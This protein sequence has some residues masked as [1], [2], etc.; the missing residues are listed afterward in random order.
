VSRLVE[1]S[2]KDL[3]GEVNKLHQDYIMPCVHSW[4]DVVFVEGRGTTLKD[5]EGKEYLDCFAGVAVVNAGHCHPKIVEAVREQ[6]GKLTH[7]SSLFQTV[8]EAYLA[9]KISDSLPIQRGKPKKVYFCNSGSE[10]NDHAIILAKKFS[11]KFEI[12]GLQNGYHGR[13]GSTISASGI[14]SWLA[15]M[16]PFVPGFLHAPSYYCYRCPLGH[17][18]GPP[19]C[20]YACAQYIKHMLNTETSSSVAAFI[21]EPAYGVGGVIPAPPDYF[22]EVKRILDANNILFIADEVQTGF[23]RMG[24]MFGIENY[25]VDP[26]IMTMAKGLASGFPIGAVASTSEIADSYHGP[27]FS[28]YGGN[29][30]SCVAALA[31]LDVL[32]EEKLVENSARVGAHTL[33]VMIALEERHPSLDCVDGKGLMIGA[34]V[35]K[36]K[37]TREPA[38]DPVLE[39]ILRGMLEKGVIIGRGGLFYNRIRF[40]PPLCITEAEVDRAMDAID[41]TLS[42]VEKSFGI[43]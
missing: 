2:S 20:G 24:R 31:N 37:R 28:T 35:V 30:V 3:K 29:P 12:I 22:K 41:S 1:Q 39:A 34:E 18:E 9:K 38:G 25:G 15:D 10:A 21:A 36:S 42:E 14:G 32:E 26:D 40:Q 4:H 17:T 11:R 5:S 16:G 8:P 23:G 19:K 6:A 43:S 27:T 7:L 13:T 33:K